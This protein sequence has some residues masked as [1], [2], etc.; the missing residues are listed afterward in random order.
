M[1]VPVRLQMRLHVHDPASAAFQ[2]AV[3]TGQTERLLS[4][5]QQTGLVREMGIMAG[6]AAFLTGHRSVLRRSAVLQRSLIGMAA[7]A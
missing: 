5:H 2:L 3:M 6:A 4:G 7:C 1:A